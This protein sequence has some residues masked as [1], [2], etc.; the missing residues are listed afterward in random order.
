MSFYTALPKILPY[1]F[2]DL[3]AVGDQ[4]VGDLIMRDSGSTVTFSVDVVAD[5]CP[6]VTWILDS[7]KLGPIAMISLHTT[8]PVCQLMQEAP[9]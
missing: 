4:Y 2:T 1:N 7:I 5:P 6:N 8:T 9:I 3:G